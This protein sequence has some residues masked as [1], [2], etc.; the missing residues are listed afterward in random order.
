MNVNANAI[1]IK[2]VNHVEKKNI[3]GN[4]EIKEENAMNVEVK[5]I[6]NITQR[7]NEKQKIFKQNKSEI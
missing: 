6:R 5:Q 2:N 3:Y 7:R 1:N 4:M